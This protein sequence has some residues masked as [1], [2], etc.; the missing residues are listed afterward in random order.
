MLFL[1][2][3]ME[4]SHVF[5]THTFKYVSSVFIE[6]FVNYMVKKGLQNMHIISF[7]AHV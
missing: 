3:Y 2:T 7:F 1:I 6:L 4:W 5:H